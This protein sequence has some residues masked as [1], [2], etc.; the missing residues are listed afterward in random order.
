MTQKYLHITRD[1]TKQIHELNPQITYWLGQNK[2]NKWTYFNIKYSKKILKIEIYWWQKSTKYT[3][4]EKTTTV[5]LLWDSKNKHSINTNLMTQDKSVVINKTNSA[6][7]QL[8]QT[9]PKAK[10]KTTKFQK[11]LQYQLNLYSSKSRQG[12]C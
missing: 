6:F 1:K 11:Q 3:K 12:Y 5:L 10:S 7:R 9:L 2:T 4:I 8:K